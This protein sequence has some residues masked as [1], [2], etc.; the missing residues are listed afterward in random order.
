MKYWGS[1]D[2]DLIVDE[3]TSPLIKMLSHCEFVLEKCGN[4]VDAKLCD[5]LNIISVQDKII[6][7]LAAC[8]DY[9]KRRD[10]ESEEGEEDGG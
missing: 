9:E 7:A 3:V 8:R 4:V 2:D 10:K 1:K 5:G 6:D